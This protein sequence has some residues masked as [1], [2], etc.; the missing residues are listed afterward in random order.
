M[1]L[2]LPQ[3]G[4]GEPPEMNVICPWLG[5]RLGLLFAKGTRRSPDSVVPDPLGDV[6]DTTRCRVDAEGHS[7]AAV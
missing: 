5:R 4:R 3:N 1:F 6:I 2:P 7:S